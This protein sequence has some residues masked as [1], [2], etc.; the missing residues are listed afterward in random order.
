MQVFGNEFGGSRLKVYLWF[1]VLGLLIHA[2]LQL[3]PPYMDFLRMKDTMTVKAGVAQVL[4]DE[5]IMRDLVAKAKE[6]DLPLTEEYFIMDRDNDRRRMKISTAWD[7]DVKFLGNVYV[8]T[9]HFRPVVDES[10][11]SFMR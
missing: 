4:K 7:V 6:L 11:M 9:Y 10:F 2:A 8:Y 1:L 5:E 3:V